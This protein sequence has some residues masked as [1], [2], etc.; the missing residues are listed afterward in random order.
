MQQGSMIYGL[1][2]YFESEKHIDMVGVEVD[3][4]R[5]WHSESWGARYSCHRTSATDFVA[6]QEISLGLHGILGTS[7]LNLL[8][9]CLF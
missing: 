3:S 8:V 4:A 1:Y 2:I 9:L 5:C 7:F 6:K